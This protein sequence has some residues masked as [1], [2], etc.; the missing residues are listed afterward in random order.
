MG[1]LFVGAFG[2]AD[3]HSKRQELLIEFFKVLKLINEVVRCF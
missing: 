2:S 1:L 3:S